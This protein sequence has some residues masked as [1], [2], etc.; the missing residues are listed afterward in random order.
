MLILII[1]F[2]FLGFLSGSLFGRFLNK[3]VCL[4]T[5][6]FTFFSF[7]LSFTLLLDI[8]QSGN[9]YILNVTK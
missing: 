8:I 4:I 2:P 7:L 6:L 5:T 3:G 1:L 9:T